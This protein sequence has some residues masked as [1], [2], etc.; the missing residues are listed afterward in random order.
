MKEIEK[1]KRLIDLDIEKTKLKKEQFIK[2]I[3]SGLGD[4]I[5]KTG[6]KITKI[7]REE[8]SWLR[9]VIDKIMEVF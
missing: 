2:E 8:K 6:N 1:E 4:H 9:K 3:R 7:K 5:K